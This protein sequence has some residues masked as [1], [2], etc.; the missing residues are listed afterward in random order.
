MW[1]IL[2]RTLNTVRKEPT[3]IVT[4]LRI[5]EREERADQFAL[6]RQKASGFIPPGRPK[7][8]RSRAFEVLEK[9]VQQRIEGN[10]F[11][12]REDNKLWLIRH[13]EVIRLL[14]LEDMKVIQSL[15]VPCFP[16]SYDIVKTYVT[17][18]HNSLSSHLN[19]I[20]DNGLEGN[21][22]VTLLAWVLNTYSG[23]EL[24]GHPSLDCD[25]NKFEP[26]LSAEVL[27]KLQ[28]TYISNVE[29]NYESWMTNALEL[30]RREWFGTEPPKQNSEEQY[31]TDLAQ[32]LYNMI[33]QNLDVATTISS[34]IQVQVL[35]SSLVKVRQFATKYEVAITKYK[36]QYFEDRSKIQYF[37]I[38]MI[39]L[40][41][42]CQGIMDNM[43]L[44]KSQYWRPGGST[45]DDTKIAT[46]FDALSTH[47]TNLR[48]RVCDYLLIE[49]HMDLKK[50]F[51]TLITQ[52]WLNNCES[53]DTICLTLRDYFVD[54][55]SLSKKNFDRVVT[56][57]LNT[58]VIKYITAILEKRMTLRTQED[59]KKVAIRI[60]EEA[61]KLQSVFDEVVEVTSKFE[62]PCEALKVVAEVIRASDMEFLSLE[63]HR[64]LRRYPDVNS[65][66]LTALLLFRGD[67]NRLEARQRVTETLEE[68]RNQRSSGHNPK[69]IFTDIHINVS[70]FH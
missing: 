32:H 21:E 69:S 1:I 68:M 17:M 20:I 31:K 19:D 48:I 5:I 10:Q 57:A 64:M 38:Y 7:R 39:A 16:P 29:N 14:V 67:V 56:N 65:D 18:Y 36:D 40:A 9:A 8:W 26:L 33:K 35:I 61:E 47:Y 59:R 60:T 58:V 50:A 11:E 4:A 34:S 44:I 37:T 55:T 2:Q 25:I 23:K 22:Y 3:H 54:Y 63:F 49:P 41:N 66:H 43:S 46:E 6:S 62:S 28:Q 24:M 15:C 27:Q 30:E 52:E 13:L 70:I 45:K 12:E 42:S 53:L 51:D